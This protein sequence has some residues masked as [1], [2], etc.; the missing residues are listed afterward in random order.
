MK[1]W[2]LGRSLWNLQGDHYAFPPSWYREFPSSI[3]QLG[4]CHKEA[5]DHFL[6]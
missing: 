2:G 3:C 5:E 6:S 4:Q 1:T